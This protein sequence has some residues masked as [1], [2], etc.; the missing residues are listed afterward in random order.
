MSELSQTS[1]YP[2]Q[3]D[4]PYFRRLWNSIVVALLGAA[5]IPLML[6]GGGMYYFTGSALKQKTLQSLRAEVLNHKRSVDRFL[7]ERTLDLRQLAN[8]HDLAALTRPGVL[9]AVLRTLP[10]GAETPWFADLGVI[11]DHGRHL[12]YVGPY[13]L[14]SR[15]YAE[16]QWFKAVMAQGV[17]ISDV[18][19]GF[20]NVPHFIIA[21]TKTEKGSTWIVRATVDAVFFDRL[22]T[23]IAAKTGGNAFLINQKGIFQTKAGKAGQIQGQSDLMVPERFDGIRLEEYKDK[24]A[25]MGWL[26][27]VPWLS[28]VQ[29]ERGSILKPLQRV[30][31]IG[32]SV[33]LLGAII[34]VFTVLL[35]TNHLVQRL[36]T[37]RRS[38]RTLNQQLRQT[39]RM[40]SCAQL[41]FGFFAEIKE[42][43]VNLDI[44][45]QLAQDLA[46]KDS[47][48]P[49]N[50][51][52]IRASLDAIRSTAR[53]G[54]KSIDMILAVTRPAPPIIV[55]ININD[56]LDE[57]IRLFERARQ[58]KNI[59]I[60][61]DYYDKPPPVR[62]DPSQ[63]SQVFQNLV[64]NA[65]T[66][67][68]ENGLII[69]QTR[70]KKTSMQVAV[71]DN[72]PGIPGEN[73]EKIFEPFFSTK[74]DRMGLGLS[75]SRNIL[76]KLGGMIRVNSRPGKETAFIVELPFEFKTSNPGKPVE[77]KWKSRFSGELK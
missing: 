32:L 37:K 29:M 20:R 58:F 50:L 3:K 17:Y 34:I 41:S 33:F 43:L 60:I 13:D 12:A 47:A 69:V 9:E 1:E 22:V 10:A 16:A 63:L 64:F 28:V 23:E 24:L 18:F 35:T 72:G 45:A 36:E 51:P 56:L 38:I 54:I 52:E 11:D 77:T 57:L 55:D 46:V 53:N 74:P 30:R 39:S 68:G 71:A 75:V 6:I 25:A 27:K 21:V 62:S 8:T 48:G 65:I 7:A 31:N 70:R 14:I 66:A 61:R 26:D 44:A 73:L 42:Q 5:F 76:E 15:N 40:A 49:A 4:F 19:S 59:E 2:P 67:L